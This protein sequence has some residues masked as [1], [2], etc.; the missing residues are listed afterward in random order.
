MSKS[1]KPLP[2]TIYFYEYLF[3]RGDERRIKAK[4]SL[5]ELQ[6]RLAAAT[7]LDIDEDF[8]IGNLFQVGELF[9]DYGERTATINKKQVNKLLSG[10]PIFELC[11]EGIV[12]ASPNSGAEAKSL[13]EKLYLKH[14]TTEEEEGSW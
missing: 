7:F 13:L 5:A 11:E 1:K 10:K 8:E 9:F 2:K 3:C 12:T 14:Y 6:K 4:L